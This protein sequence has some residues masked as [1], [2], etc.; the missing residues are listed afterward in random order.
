MNSSKPIY[1]YKM[2]S[3]NGGAPCV[4]EGLLSL[5]ICKP[6]IRK[7]A[8]I[9]SLIFGFGGKDLDDRLIYVARVTG[10]LVDG[11][12]YRAKCFHTRPDCIHRDKNSQTVMA[13][14]AR[15]HTDGSQIEKD[16]GSRFENANV[17]LSHDFRYLGA[18]GTA[19]YKKSYQDLS[20]VLDDLM[21]G[22]RV[23]HDRKVYKE[24]GELKRDLW[25]NHSF[26]DQGEHSDKD[27]TKPCNRE[28]KCVR[29]V[30]R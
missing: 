3:D 11:C 2:T 26:T 8:P 13:K 21:Q 27:V 4:Y 1:V 9:G 15:Y 7:V 23:N 18:S 22:H 29:F 30:P 24:L 19:N 5:A 12:Y 17:L 6:K 25:N 14:N 10:K 28:S 20:D 16:V